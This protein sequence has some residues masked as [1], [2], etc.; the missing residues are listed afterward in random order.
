MNE[1]D[2]DFKAFLRRH[3]DLSWKTTA[4]LL[5][6]DTPTRNGHVY[7]RALMEREIARYAAQHCLG[8]LDCHERNGDYL[9]GVAVAIQGLR[10]DGPNVVGDVVILDTIAGR[11][12][13]E[14]LRCG[15][16]LS[17]S[18]E[19]AGTLA[20]DGTVENYQL[21]GFTMG[22]TPGLGS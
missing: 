21:T 2:L 19:G 8:R 20:D 15:G 10:M 14:Y 18:P 4:V 11:M 5:R 22:A 7:P 9:N 13:R 3:R 1:V 17:I 12:L 16:K 6:C